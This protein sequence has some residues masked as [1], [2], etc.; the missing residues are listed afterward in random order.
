MELF[1]MELLNDNKINELEDKIDAIISSYT[2]IKEENKKLEIKVK[3]L[4]EENGSLKGKTVEADT[5]RQRIAEKVRQI[6][7][8]IEKVEV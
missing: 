7:E 5:E 4:E 8:K 2:A 3:V 1:S 6:L